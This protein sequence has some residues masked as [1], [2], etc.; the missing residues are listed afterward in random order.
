MAQRRRGLAVELTRG[1][2]L[3]LAQVGALYGYSGFEALRRIKASTNELIAA[4]MVQLLKA[5]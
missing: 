3:L 5:R 4:V 2:G 1:G